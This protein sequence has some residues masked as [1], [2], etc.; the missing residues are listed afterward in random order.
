MKPTVCIVEDNEPLRDALEELLGTEFDI[1]ALEN[2]SKLIEYLE[3]KIPDLILLDIMLPFPLDG[4]SILRLL[5]NNEALAVIP[6]ILMS[7]INSEDKITEGL[8]LG[9]NDYI[10]KPFKSNNLFLK[11]KNQVAIH[12]QKQA[13]LEKS[14]LNNLNYQ[15]DSPVNNFKKQ[16]SAIMEDFS[17]NANI[18][19]EEIA[20]KMLM[21]VSTLERWMKKIYGKS[22]RKFMLSY[23]MTKAEILLRQNMGSVKDIAYIL[24]FNSV[25][26]FCKCF[27]EKYGTSPLQYTKK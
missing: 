26:Y 17:D 24:G 2:G 20:S 21:S 1:T 18:S 27:K 6:V 16:I 3:M 4:F 23:K 13:S 5:K 15:V 25:S 10:V 14:E 11:I 8:E 12:K 7:A 9:A 22:P 19:V